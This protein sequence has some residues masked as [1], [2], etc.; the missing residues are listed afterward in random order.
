[1]A[2]N[3]Y[4]TSG[5]AANLSRHDMLAWVNTSLKTNFVKIEEMCTGAHYCLFMNILFPGY[6]PMARV[7]FGA[8]LEH[9]FIH[10]FKILQAVFK[11]LN[12][13]KI[14]PIDR[15]IKGRFQDNFEFLQWFK[16]FHD[17][18]KGRIPN[19]GDAVRDTSSASVSIRGEYLSKTEGLR[20]QIEDMKVT[21]EGLE[22]E[23][24]FF[25]RKLRSIEALCQDADETC[26]FIQK[27]LD[28]LYE[29]ED[30]FVVPGDNKDSDTEGAVE[31]IGEGDEF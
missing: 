7:K 27:I 6:V 11:K 13:D 20:S 1:M 18:N 17:A 15:L 31:G 3:V 30:G 9:E 2:V 23:R 12:V 28:I 29:I 5:T 21:I 8:Y 22:K 10:N 14:V 25:S 4:F 26:P 19:D 16:K 24:D